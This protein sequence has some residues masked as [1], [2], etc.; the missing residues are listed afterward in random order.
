MPLTAQTDH[1]KAFPSRSKAKIIQTI[2]SVHIQNMFKASKSAAL[3]EPHSQRTKGEKKAQ[4]CIVPESSLSVK[5][6]S[7]PNALRATTLPATD[8]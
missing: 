1:L 6:A 2:I 8:T 5:N 4:T 3:H 7:F